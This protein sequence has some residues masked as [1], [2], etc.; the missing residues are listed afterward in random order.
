MAVKTE[1]SG[2]NNYHNYNNHSVI[3]RRKQKQM[4]HVRSDY[5][6]VISGLRKVLDKVV[7]N[8]EPA[9]RDRAVKAQYHVAEL[10]KLFYETYTS[11]N[12]VNQ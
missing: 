4:K 10:S 9:L 5:G 1:Y 12:S 3:V 2:N 6:R 7:I 11:A 8:S